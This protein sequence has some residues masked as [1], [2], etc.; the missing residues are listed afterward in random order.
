MAIV[1]PRPG[2]YA[3]SASVSV[4]VLPCGI[5][6][7]LGCPVPTRTRSQSHSSRSP[8][9]S[10]R[11]WLS[12]ENNRPPS[13]SSVSSPL[14]H[15]FS[16]RSRSI[17]VTETCCFAQRRRSLRLRGLRALRVSSHAGASKSSKHTNAEGANERNH[18]GHTVVLP[19]ACGAQG[20]LSLFACAAHEDRPELGRP[21]PHTCEPPPPPNHPDP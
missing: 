2:V 17:S 15:H 13:P 1:H 20:P 9:P 10:F 3:V 12:P 6:W 19:L 21:P 8:L 7:W 4:E 18:N 14:A 16:L 11:N 5:P